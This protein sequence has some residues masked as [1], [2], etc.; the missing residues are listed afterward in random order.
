MSLEASTNADPMSSAEPQLREARGTETSPVSRPLEKSTVAPP[1]KKTRTAAFFNKA[2]GNDSRR[3]C[4]LERMPLEIL[5]EILSYVPYPP[6]ILALARCSKYF[7]HALVN[8]SSTTF[9]WRN[10]RKRCILASGRKLPEPTANFT[11]AS[12]A[13]FV[14]DYGHCEICK[15]YVRLHYT[16]YSL[17]TRVCQHVSVFH[18]FRAMSVTPNVARQNVEIRGSKYDADTYPLPR[19]L[20][21]SDQD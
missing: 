19:R 4:Y 18:I 6:S 1:K 17:R 21:C 20:L 5:A 7:C 15:S 9:I 13:A 14:F 12:Y 10:A 16:S 11:E 8:N 2:N 3:P